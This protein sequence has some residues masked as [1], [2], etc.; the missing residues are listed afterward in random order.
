MDTTLEH[1]LAGEVLAE[2]A[3]Q[4]VTARE[5]QRRTGIKPRTWENY[6]VN[7]S[8]R[9]PLR[10]VWEIGD[11][12]G[13]PGSELMRRAEARAG[14][15]AAQHEADAER[16]LSSIDPELAERVRRVDRESRDAQEDDPLMAERMTRPSQSATKT[17]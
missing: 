17:G 15:L 6:F 7:R 11:V 5:M 4:Q 2:V 3:R 16:G 1:A 12:L 13:V 14:D 10:V 8:T 9:I